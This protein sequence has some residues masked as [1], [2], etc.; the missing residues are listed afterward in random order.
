MRCKP[1]NGLTRQLHPEGE[2]RRH[3]AELDDENCIMHPGNATMLVR[4]LPAGL[5]PG[6]DALIEEGTVTTLFVKALLLS[7][8]VFESRRSVHINAGAAKASSS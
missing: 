5:E 8:A 3:L 7:R 4:V 2:S 1:P 6:T